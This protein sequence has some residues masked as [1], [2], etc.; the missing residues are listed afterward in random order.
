MLLVGGPKYSSVAGTPSLSIVVA[1]VLSIFQGPQVESSFN[2]MGNIIND[3]AP[4]L[5]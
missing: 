4:G 3:K 5:T 1:G 2:V